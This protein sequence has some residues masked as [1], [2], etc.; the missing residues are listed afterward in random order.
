MRFI[1]SWKLRSEATQGMMFTHFLICS[2]RVD[3]GL[4]TSIAYSSWVESFS[5][6]VLPR[7]SAAVARL[8]VLS[9]R[10]W[11]WKRAKMHW[12]LDWPHERR[13]FVWQGWSLATMFNQTSQRFA[14]FDVVRAFA[15]RRRN[16][17]MVADYVLEWISDII[18]TILT[19]VI[20]SFNYDEDNDACW[21]IQNKR[22]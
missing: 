22:L 14:R 15:V 9:F 2:Y 17:S 20:Y 16:V 1:M 7:R 3:L 21:S 19:N 5:K 10:Y 13:N 6:I 4:L 8:G 12:S 18:R 11:D